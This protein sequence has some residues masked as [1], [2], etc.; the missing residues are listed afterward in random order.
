M[1]IYHVVDP[2]KFRLNQG[3]TKSTLLAI[4]YFNKYFHNNVVVIYPLP[5]RGL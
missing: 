4:D 3:I 5:F 1:V 2:I